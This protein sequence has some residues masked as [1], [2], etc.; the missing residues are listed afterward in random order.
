MAVYRAAENPI[1]RPEDVRPSREDFEVIGVFNAGVARYRNEVILLLRVAERLVA[2]RED[3]VLSPIY[4]VE[5]GEITIRPFARDDPRNDFSDPRLIV[6]RASRPCVA[7]PSWPRFLR[8][9]APDV[10]GQDALATTETYLTSISHLRLARSR[11]GIRFQIA[12]GPTI[13]PANEYETFGIEDPRVTTWRGRPALVPRGEGVSPLHPVPTGGDPEYYIDYVGVSPRGVT[14]CLAS[15][16]NFQSFERYGVLFHP[17]NKDVVI[18]P[19]RIGGKF[20]ALHRP[21]SSLFLRNDIWIAESPDLICWGNHRHLMGTR[22]GLW[23]ETRIGAG[24]VP[25]RIEEGWLEFYHG[26][27]RNNRYC[28]GAVLLDGEQPWKIIARSETPVFEPQADYERAGFFGNVVFSCGLLFEDDTL[29]VYYGA[30][31]TSICYAEIPLADVCANLN[32]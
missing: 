23:D 10:Q 13:R 6:T 22:D 30:A 31:D 29:K 32:R 11:D 12:D 20:Y 7:R 26:A 1:I 16:R 9:G 19:S 21:H 3:V 27:D 8:H 15:T 4:D 5:T 28:M 18:F 2:E 25:F 14:T 17:D 24:A